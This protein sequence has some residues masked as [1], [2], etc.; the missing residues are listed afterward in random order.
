MATKKTTAKRTT[1]KKQTRS[2]YGIKEKDTPKPK[3]KKVKPIP[4]PNRIR[5][6]MSLANQDMAYTSGKTYKVGRDVSPET[7]KS[8]L[9]SGA[10]EEDRSEEPPETK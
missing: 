7:A 3:P 1:T 8:W 4:T 2:E 5:M 9:R 10:A 6:L